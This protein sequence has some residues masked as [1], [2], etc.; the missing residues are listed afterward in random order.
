[1]MPPGGMP[2]HGYGYDAP[3]RNAWHGHGYDAPGG[4]PGMPG[5]PGGAMPGMDMGM[6][7]PGGMPGMPGGAMPGMDMGMMPPWRDAWNAWWCNARNGY[8]YDAP[9]GMPECLVV[10][11]PEWIWV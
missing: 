2:W 7:P 4:M 8:G 10:Q 1:M 9:G 3:W 6:M 5:M 11:C